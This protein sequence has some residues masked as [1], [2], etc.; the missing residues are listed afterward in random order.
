MED[1]H[2]S[3]NFQ[4]DTINSSHY[5]SINPKRPKIIKGC[6]MG[7]IVIA[8]CI[9]CYFGF[10][11]PHGEIDCMEDY[12]HSLTGPINKYLH[13]NTMLKNFL[14]IISSLYMDSIVIIMSVFWTLRSKSWRFLTTALIFYFFRGLVQQTFQMKYPEGYLWDYPGFPSLTVSYLKTNDFFFSGHVGFPVIAACE[15]SKNGKNYLAIFALCGCLV[16]FVVMIFMRGHYI[17]DLITGVI[18]SHYFFILVDKY[19]HFID[20]SRISLKDHDDVLEEKNSF[21]NEPDREKGISI[22][23]YSK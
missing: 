12:S 22:V 15:F 18:V 14:T 2:T 3:H 8:I 17:I 7:L 11:L 9:N 5:R 23:K 4:I 13:E 16:E 1:A 19:I 20:N 21:K 10:G 6:I